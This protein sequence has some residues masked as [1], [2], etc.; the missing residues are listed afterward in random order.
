MENKLKDMSRV[1]KSAREL[2]MSRLEHSE[3]K[4]GEW[5]CRRGRQVRAHSRELL[6]VACMYRG[7]QKRMELGLYTCC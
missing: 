2:Q 1:E 7:K 4:G 6:K 3:G 5:G